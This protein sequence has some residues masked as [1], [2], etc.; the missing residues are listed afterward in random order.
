MQIIAGFLKIAASL[1]RVNNPEPGTENVLPNGYSLHLADCP[2]AL[3]R[4]ASLAVAGPAGF[5]CAF[6]NLI[7]APCGCG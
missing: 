7:H 5:A 6:P 3:D 1:P 2:V 4:T